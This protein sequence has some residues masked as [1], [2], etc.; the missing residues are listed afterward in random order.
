MCERYE[1]LR[2]L[3][4]EQKAVGRLHEKSAVLATKSLGHWFI[5]AA[6]ARV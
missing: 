4:V 2:M 1:F 5:A 6:F 3:A